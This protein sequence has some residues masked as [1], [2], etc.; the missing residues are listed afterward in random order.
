MFSIDVHEILWSVFE[1]IET[2]FYFKA[3]IK[4]SPLKEVVLLTCMRMEVEFDKS[5][6]INGINFKIICRCCRKNA[7]KDLDDDDEGFV[8]SFGTLE[9]VMGRMC[10]KSLT[11]NTKL[12][13]QVQ[14]IT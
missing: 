8:S 13:S 9:D 12:S 14:E 6:S 11:A 7:F 5:H 3:A 10:A 2:D 4:K 1:F